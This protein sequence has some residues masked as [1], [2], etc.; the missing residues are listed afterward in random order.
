MKNIKVLTIVIML[1]IGYTFISFAGTIETIDGFKMYKLPSGEY[2]RDT[3]CFVDF[4]GD[5]IKECYRFDDRGHI[6]ANYISED[7]RAT[8]DKGQLIE[9]GFVVEK[10]SNGKIRYGEG[11]PY[12]NTDGMKS[13][14][15]DV[16]TDNRKYPN[17]SIENKDVIKTIEIDDDFIGPI[18]K[19]I[20][21][22]VIYA[23]DTGVSTIDISSS[24]VNI[25]TNKQNKAVAGKNIKNFIDKKVNCKVDVDDSI[26]YGGIL[27]DDSIE[28]RGTGAS[29][30]FN[31]KNNNYMY[32]EVAEEPHVTDEKDINICLEVYVDNEL[33]DTID[34]F[35]EGEPYEF[36]E[37]LFDTKKIELKVKSDIYTG[38]RI[39]IH[40]GRFKKVKEDE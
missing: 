12:V 15:Y 24:G 36:S 11:N 28:L 19:G 1:S 21:N 7:G 16:P 32:F 9:N 25:N 27:W 30:S 40:N 39:Y 13:Y 2:A 33:Y 35:V 38:R 14:V 17:S 3:W 5:S 8:N 29:V 10:L 34:E 23:G 4:N 26:I 22:Q 37:E 20:S 6:V 31:L 18:A